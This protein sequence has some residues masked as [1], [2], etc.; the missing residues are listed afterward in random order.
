MQF[1]AISHNFTQFRAIV[2]ARGQ[3]L[4]QSFGDMHNITHSW[5]DCDSSASYS[6]VQAIPKPVLWGHL[7]TWAIPR[8]VLW[9]HLCTWAI[10]GPVLWRHLCTRA[11]PGPVLW[12]HLCTRTIPGPVLWRHLCTRAIPRVVLWRR[13]QCHTFMEWLRFLGQS[14]MHADYIGI[15]YHVISRN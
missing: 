9:G 13:A 4:G 8:P 6:C 2:L 1:H 5:S 7:C 14:F 3:F 10:P 11:I 15:F 12:G